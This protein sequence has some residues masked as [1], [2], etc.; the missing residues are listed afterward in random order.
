MQHKNRQNNRFMGKIPILLLILGVAIFLGFYLGYIP[1]LS[2]TFSP[3][4]I[5]VILA[6]VLGG[7][8]SS[9]RRSRQKRQVNSEVRTQT[10]YRQYQPPEAKTEEKDFTSTPKYQYRNHYEQQFCNYCGIKLETEEQ[11]FCVNCGQKIN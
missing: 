2:W 8:S 9:R 6:V 3:L 1:N 10:P 7:L 5:I 4:V 11:S